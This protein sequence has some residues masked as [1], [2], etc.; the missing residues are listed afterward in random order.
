MATP[1]IDILGPMRIAV[2]GKESCLTGQKLRCILAVLSLRAG[3]PVRRDELIEEL[4]LT[5]TSDAS[6]SLHAHIARLR[7]WLRMQS[8]DS[9]ILESVD[10]SYRLNIDRGAVDAY[11]FEDRVEQALALY[12][13]APSVVAVMLT[14]ALAMWRGD[15]LADV[16]DGPFVA[17]KTEELRHLRA[18]AREILLSAWL[19]TGQDRRVILN[20]RRFLDADP[21]NEQL[22][23]SLIVALRRANRYAEA[24]KA[25][26][27]ANLLYHAELGIAPGDRLRIA[28]SGPIPERLTA[29]R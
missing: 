3:Q 5:E 20:A 1:E 21:L 4:R 23:E 7:R 19:D 10:S 2:D 8:V 16:D 22:W 11:I 28:L 25:F 6:N 29:D 24:S 27:E 18:T 14:E 26:R 12:P 9:G 15:A 13:S 17:S